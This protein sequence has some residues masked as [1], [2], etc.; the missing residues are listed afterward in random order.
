MFRLARGTQSPE[1]GPRQQPLPA[2]TETSHERTRLLTRNPEPRARPL[3]QR[4]GRGPGGQPR[5]PVE[6]KARSAEELIANNLELVELLTGGVIHHRNNV[7][8][9]SVEGAVAT[10]DGTFGEI[11]DRG[12]VDAFL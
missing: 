8:F 2:G 4:R 5:V 12:I 11:I 3:L 9:D 6:P 10:L 1:V 7:P